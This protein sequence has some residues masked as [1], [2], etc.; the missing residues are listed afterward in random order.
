MVTVYTSPTCAYCHFVE[1]F[2]KDKKVSYEKVD[3][4]T[5]PDASQWVYDHVG[6]LATPVI[7]IDGTVI[8]GF[9]RPKLQAALTEKKL[10]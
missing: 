6:Q 4:S 2:L 8:L 1:E 3:I 5:D 7:D 9:D 10:I